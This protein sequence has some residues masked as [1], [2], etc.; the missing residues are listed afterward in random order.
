MPVAVREHPRAFLSGKDKSVTQYSAVR[1]TYKYR[2]YRCDKRD[3]FLHQQINVAGCIW[4]HALA[5]H[6]RYYALTGKYIP[7]NRLK[8]HV[9]RLRMKTQRYGFWKALGSQAVQDVLE[10]LDDAYARFFKRI[11]K[12]P[13]KFRKVKRYPSFTLK[14]AGYRL[15]EG[16]KIRIGSKTYKFAKQRDLMGEVK[17]LT[18]KRDSLGRLWLCFS[19]VEKTLEPSPSATSEVAG[20]DF[21]LKTFLTDHTGKAY[22]SPLFYKQELKRI[23]SLSRRKDKKSKG[24]NNRRKAARLLVRA[25]IRIADKRRDYHFQ[26][27]HDL[28]DTFDVLVFEDLNLAGMKAMWGRKVSDLGFGQ[29]MEIVKYVA[30]KRGKRV[31]Q[32]AR[33]ERTTGKCSACGQHQSLELRERTFHCNTCGLQ[34]DRDHNAALNIRARA[35]AHTTLEVVSPVSTGSLV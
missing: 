14:Q 1:R 12:R 34:L 10:R 26:L 25:H 15:L 7:L 31:E 2:L 18:V 30:W 9:A 28:C 17:T 6:K 21:G 5:L 13:P 35:L 24:S 27:A 8:A 19:V 11:A 22:M 20:F 33:W 29:F 32:I 23:K 16:N 4:N 3:V